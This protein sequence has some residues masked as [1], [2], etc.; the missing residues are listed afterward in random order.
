MIEVSAGAD[1]SRAINFDRARRSHGSNCPSV[2]EPILILLVVRNFLA[3]DFANFLIHAV[4]VSF[5]LAAQGLHR[6]SIKT[7]DNFV[8]HD[9]SPM[10]RQVHI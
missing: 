4:A 3:D 9:R 7:D 1:K 8:F 10:I 2:G 6:L 5:G